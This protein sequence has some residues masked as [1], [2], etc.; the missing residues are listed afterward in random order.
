MT[1]TT[2][3]MEIKTKNTKGKIPFLTTVCSFTKLSSCL[4]V[5]WNNLYFCNQENS[6]ITIRVRRRLEAR[7]WFFIDRARTCITQ[8]FALDI[9]QTH[10]T[11][12]TCHCIL[13][14]LCCWCC[15]DS[16]SSCSFLLCNNDDLHNNDEGSGMGEI[17]KEELMTITHFCCLF[18]SSLLNISQS[19]CLLHHN[20][21]ENRKTN[22]KKL[23]Q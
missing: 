9:Q 23:E 16:S 15:E 17:I 2:R 4:Y 12:I 3:P 5:G 7:L 10:Q 6:W 18:S 21:F 13:F 8:S 22:I 19:L 14:F 20:L 1:M 11:S